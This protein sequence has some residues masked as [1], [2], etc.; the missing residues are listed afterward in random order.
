MTVGLFVVLGV[1]AL[2]V[3]TVFSKRLGVAAPLVLVVAGIGYSF[4]PGVPEVILP[5]DVVLEVILPL[6]L[7]AAAVQ[8][9][10]VDFRRNLSAIASL[11]VVLVFASAFVV[12]VVLRAILPDLSFGAALALGAVVSP[13][14]AV[15]ATSIAKR[16]G[17]PARVV[18]ILEGES[19]VNDASALVLLRAAL[20]AIGTALSGWGLVGDFAFSLVVALA[21]GAVVGVATVLVR[22]R[23]GDSVLDTALSFTVPFLAFIPVQALGAS[24]IVA[25]VTAGLISGASAPRLLSARA[26]LS[27]RLNWRTVQFVLENGVFLLMGAQLVPIIQDVRTADHPEVG[28][29][30]S[31][32]L[33]LLLVVVL[34][35]VRAAVIALL[36]LR[37][38]RQQNRA[39]ARRSRL[40]GALDRVSARAG[41]ETGPTS[42]RDAREG[43]FLRRRLTDLAL[44]EKADVDWR[45]GL[46]LVAAGMRG[47]VTL[48]GAQSI[49]SDVPFRNQLVLIAFA[50]AVITL[51]GQGGTLPA[52]IRATGIRG[53]D[54]AADQRRLAALVGEMT[55]AGLAALNDTGTDDDGT[56]FDEEV[57]AQVRQD[58]ERRRRSAVAR[59]TAEG[60][61]SRRP[62]E[63]YRA[64][65]GQVLSA[66]RDALL[67]ARSRAE[68]PSRI[69][70]QAQT[71]LDFDESRLDGTS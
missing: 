49:P 45:G 53:S 50:V 31:V 28:V 24:G 10:L 63:Q 1:V 35:A 25:T 8:V 58:T 18:T 9:P 23:L 29:V 67:E 33:A 21:I 48:A 12:A 65:R 34:I 22:S 51:L 61:E 30:E 71:M 68:Y 47:V 26:R 20:A 66:E 32:L 27:E 5:P 55:E 54:Q 70:E 37:L 11:S 7:Y 46:V 6:L 69:L 36:A 39:P 42:G 16:L 44:V 4:V 64:L 13:T 52:L 17:L 3:V 14:D 2:V 57:V 40:S 60:E 59:S 62:H 41:S 56:R 15:A 19:L 43:R 38:R